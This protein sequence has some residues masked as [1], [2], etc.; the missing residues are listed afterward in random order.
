MSYL[1][2][3]AR[4][5]FSFIYSTPSAP[6]LEAHY[7][8]TP[9][10]SSLLSSPDVPSAV[11]PKR[12]IRPLPKRTLKSRLSNED[13]GSI[14]FPP[15][16]PST[17]LPRYAGHGENGEYSNESK[18]LIQQN[19]EVFSQDDDEE[20]CDHYDT[21]H[22]KQRCRCRHDSFDDEFEGAG[23]RSPAALRRANGYRSS[24][25]SPRSSRNSRYDAYGKSINR[26]SEPAD[27]FENSNNKKKRKIPTSGSLSLHHSSLAADMAHLGLSAR[28]GADD[29]VAYH[30]GGSGLGV[31]GA[32]RGRNGRK[33][34]GRNPLSV[35][36]NGT[37]ARSVAP[38][39]DAGTSTSRAEDA[40][41]DQGIISAAIAN[42]TA[43]LR[44]QLGKGQENGGVLDQQAKSPTD[45][46]FTFTCEGESK[47]VKFPEQS[48]YSP[49]YQQ[50]AMP[51]PPTGVNQRSGPQ[52]G[53]T[54]PAL[55]LNNA[56]A[57]HQG[58]GQTANNQQPGQGKKTRRRRGDIYVLAARQRRLQQ[59]YANLHHPPS[60]EDVWICE[61]CEYEAIFGVQPT[62]LIRQYEV[63]DRKER[64][65][66][67]E[68]RRLLE[69]AKLKGR[70]G[71][72]ATKGQAKAAAA[73][74]SAANTNHAANA[75]GGHHPT[76]AD[77]AH[78]DQYADDALY[79]HNGQPLD[80]LGPDEYLD[81]EGY[82]DDPPIAMPAPPPIQ[83]T[84]NKHQS[85][86]GAFDNGKA[87]RGAV[88]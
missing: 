32:G 16:V 62:A 11:F 27:I 68:K 41:A 67:A 45:S 12:S 18:V 43:L 58:A 78:M 88:R 75:A 63:K 4:Y 79:D 70:K 87:Q 60:S 26:N 50:R 65:R 69:K 8:I 66:L 29:D 40:K 46:Q 80:P 53:Q 5:L 71:K 28:D 52:L 72:K 37:N 25:R 2:K 15:H 9:A 83:T 7:P 48:L 36:V 54:T 73:A 20:D 6:D 22:D 39:L 23:D 44:N 34:S 59:E 55:P 49:T 17:E 77:L 30:A 47:G 74:A 13:A 56:G 86:P 33:M 81:D 61:F 35:S 84:A 42:A 38:R 24:P 19:G 51:A 14:N 85:M 1:S 21:E 82:E 76:D 57:A 31:Q 64:R 3:L 10:G